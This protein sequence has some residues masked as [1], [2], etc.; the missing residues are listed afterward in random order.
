MLVGSRLCYDLADNGIFQVY[1]TFSSKFC[2]KQKQQQYYQSPY[3]T[4]DL[5]ENIE[6]RVIPDMNDII[7]YYLKTGQTLLNKQM[8]QEGYTLS[9]KIQQAYLYLSETTTNS[10]TQ[11]SEI[12]FLV[13]N[14]LKYTEKLV[15]AVYPQQQSN[16]PQQ[17]LSLDN[18]ESEYDYG[19]PYSTRNVLQ[20]THSLTTVSSISEVQP[21]PPTNSSRFGNDMTLNMMNNI[22]K[23]FAERIDVYRKVEPTPVGVCT[24]LIL[25]LLKSFLEVTREIQLNTVNYQQIQVDIE[26][27]KRIIW[28]YAGDEK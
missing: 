28:P 5:E 13:Y 15:E 8:M 25:I 17:R 2:K 22:D 18:S 26:Y 16:T 14:R 19:G 3:N 11:V 12:W 27:I 9:T 21:L 10:V 1:S 4:A 7:E 23:L 6:P 20:S 24:G